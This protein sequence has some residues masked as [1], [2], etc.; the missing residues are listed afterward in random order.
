MRLRLEEV[1][2]QTDVEVGGKFSAL[3]GREGAF[4]V[5]YLE[6]VQALAVV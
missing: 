4:L 2:H 6:F 5:P 1:D 3:V